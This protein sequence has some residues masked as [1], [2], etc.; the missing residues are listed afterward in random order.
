MRFLSF[1]S[2]FSQLF[3]C[4]KSEKNYI[5]TPKQNYFFTFDMLNSIATNYNLET[6]AVFDS[7][8]FNTLSFYTSS[9]ENLM[10]H[11]QIL[12]FYYDIEED[13]TISLNNYDFEFVLQEPAQLPWHLGRLTTR[14][15]PLNTDFPLSEHRSCHRNNDIL[16][17]T[18]VIDTGIDIQHPEFEGR[19]VWSNNFVDDENTDCNSHGTHV[20]GLIGSHNYGICADANLFAVKVLDCQGSGSLSGVIKGIE[21]VYN[22]HKQSTVYHS[23][24]ILK[25]IINMSL[26]GSYSYSL[27]RAV[28]AC[29]KN[30]ENFYIVVAA[31]NEN[32]DACKVSPASVSNVFTVMA[33]DKNDNRA[34]F[35]NWGECADM[36]APG[37]DILS[38]IPDGKTAIYSGTSMA[39]PIMAGVLNHYIDMYPEKNMKHIFKQLLSNGTKNAIFGK[40][41]K[42]TDL[43]VYLER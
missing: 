41:P 15:L 25:T 22:E 1:I 8:E 27:N 30:S 5:L 37:V 20:A 36:Y 33:S 12:S 19:A 35:S 42:T 17:N 3:N 6:L 40:K 43:L 39:S 7:E 32:G 4:I 34:W 11:K 10:K 2:V 29:L 16:I 14:N 28:D 31:G 23:S 18:Y 9:G 21:W 13:I 26:G 24:K 38:T